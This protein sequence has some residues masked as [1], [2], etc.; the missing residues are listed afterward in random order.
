MFCTECGTQFE[1][2]FCPNCGNPARHT[3]LSSPYAGLHIDPFNGNKDITGKEYEVLCAKYL[4]SLGYSNIETTKQSGD[5]GVDIIAYKKGYKYAIQCKYY[6]SP[7]GN[8]AIQ[9]V[10]AGASFYQ[11][12]KTIVITNSSFTRGAIDL[13]KSNNVILMPRI[14]KAVIDS[15]LYFRR[16]DIRNTY[17]RYQHSLPYRV[18]YS[19]YYSYD[20]FERQYKE[21][22][23]KSNVDY[24]YLCK[25]D[26]GKYKPTNSYNGPADSWIDN[27]MYGIDD[28]LNKT[29]EDF[30]KTMLKAF[31]DDGLY[32]ESTRIHKEDNNSM[33]VYFKKKGSIPLDQLQLECIQAHVNAAS[34]ICL[35]K[36]EMVDDHVFKAIISMRKKKNDLEKEHKKFEKLQIRYY[37]SLLNGVEI[38]HYT[39]ANL[40]KTWFTKLEDEVFKSVAYNLAF[41]QVKVPVNYILEPIRLYNAEYNSTTGCITFLYYC[42]IDYRYFIDRKYN[43]ATNDIQIDQEKCLLQ[44]SAKVF[45]NE[46]YVLKDDIELKPLSPSRIKIEITDL[47]TIVENHP[48]TPSENILFVHPYDF[49]VRKE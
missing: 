17:F 8:S 28:R 21:N 10:V 3:R 38:D 24:R 30:V 45:I 36:L 42:H 43:K 37:E 44:I 32:A 23:K 29:L 5:Q 9:E 33:E 19:S 31:L 1:G 40:S 6:K 20:D 22:I 11:C 41:T 39:D 34:I 14:T 18:A 27:W 49:I 48:F 12:H 13:A 4:G 7:V 47:E 26:I 35:Y 25:K 46:Y 16:E 15:S 2:N